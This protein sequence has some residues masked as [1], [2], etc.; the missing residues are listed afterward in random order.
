MKQTRKGEY[1]NFKYAKGKTD[2]FGRIFHNHYEIYLLLGGEVEFTNNHT[3]QSI[4]PYQVVIIPPGEYHQFMVGG[5]IDDYERCV[6]DIYPGFLPGDMLNDALCGKELLSLDEC[7]RIIRHF[8]YLKECVSV[9]D[10]ADFFHIL[11]AVTTD[12]VF[13]IKNSSDAQ[14][15]YGEKLSRLSISLMN[16]LDTHFAED[17]DLDKL[18]RRFFCSVSSI[19]HVFKRDFGISI[20]KY[21]IKKRI[22][23]AC[24]A[25]QNGEK[26]EQACVKYGFGN[27]SSFYRDYKKYMGI[28]P[29]ETR[30]KKR[31]L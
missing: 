10:E 3:R 18:S 7:D 22:N 31:G 1:V 8:I 29:A 17:I 21:V 23:S 13:L 4:S 6:I 27:Y 19:C 26:P 20:K 12:I 28:S 2:I 11:S 24:M 5:N 30:G 9:V 16:Y 15:L 14:K 25:I